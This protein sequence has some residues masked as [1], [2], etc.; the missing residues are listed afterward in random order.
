MSPPA[1]SFIPLDCLGLE[2]T[3]VGCCYGL[4]RQAARSGGNTLRRAAHR[5]PKNN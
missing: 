5:Q 2:C 4:H 1:G 3:S